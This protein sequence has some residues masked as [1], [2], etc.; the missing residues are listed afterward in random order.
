MRTKNIIHLKSYPK[1]FRNMRVEMTPVD[2]AAELIIALVINS[3]FVNKV[4][5]IYNPNE[6]EFSDMINN[7]GYELNELDDDEFI[8]LLKS[9]DSKENFLLNDI[10]SSIGMLDVKVSNNVTIEELKKYNKIWPIL[11][12]D[13]IKK[14]CIYL[15]N[16]GK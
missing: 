6:I 14:I 3:G 9:Y 2:V 13:Y 8:T 16:G 5:H 4:Y 12:Y 10:I 7:L 11:N 1:S 15:E